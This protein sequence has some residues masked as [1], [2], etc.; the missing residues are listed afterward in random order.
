M[1]ITNI[2]DFVAAQK[3][4]KVSTDAVARKELYNHLKGLDA[5]KAAKLYEKFRQGQFSDMCIAF[6]ELE[7]YDD[8]L[9]TV[10]DKRDGA[11][12]AAN[13]ALIP[14]AQMIGEDEQ[15]KELADQQSQHLA[16]VF[17]RIINLNEA[18]SW[19]GTAAFRGFAHLHIEDDGGNI[20]FRPVAQWY[21]AD[22][23][24]EGTY[25]LNPSATDGSSELYELTEGEWICRHERRPIDLVAIFACVMKY[26]GE[27]GWASFNDVFGNPAIFF[28]YPA[29]TSDE[30]AKIYDEIIQQLIGEGRG[31]YPAGGKI[32]TV[33]STATKG[34]TF[35]TYIDYADKKIIRKA[36]GGE[37]TL[38]AESGTGTL[39]GGAHSDS[40]S[41][42]AVGDCRKIAAAIQRDF[43][44]R[45]LDKAFPQQPHLVEFVLEYP[46]QKDAQ[47]EASIVTSLATAGYRASDEAVS[48]IF[49]FEVTSNQSVPTIYEAKAAGYVPT[50]G[51]LSELM[52]VPLET[53]PIDPAL[54]AKGITNIAAHEDDSLFNRGDDDGNTS[55]AP[56]TEDELTFFSA[57][58]EFNPDRAE[59]RR[60]GV[61]GVLRDAADLEPANS[62]KNR[63]DPCAN[64]MRSRKTGIFARSRAALTR[65]F[66]N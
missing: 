32:V 34:E 30:R 15:L 24:L 36:L 10:A 27:Q 37:L 46:E 54:V 6:D 62:P 26:N 66:F 50:Q 52:G 29:G 31:G 8:T 58:G 42:L 38:T 41:Q 22:P 40:F 51:A 45:E 13:Y 64:P 19:L 35:Q 65:L 57:L 53:A 3:A 63:Q 17:A 23:N 49:G 16:S 9:S 11:I 28:E 59:Q 61:E 21:F 14:N 43:V 25:Y 60:E 1:A 4:Q 48:E 12:A 44:D 2:Q 39:A 56:L 55:D 47:L 33:E 18:I 5:T 7:E 20:T